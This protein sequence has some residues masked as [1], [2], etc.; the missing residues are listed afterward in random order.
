MARTR[1]IP[2]VARYP[3]DMTDGELRATFGQLP[4]SA[5]IRGL[6]L[7]EVAKI[8]ETGEARR[9][10]MRNLWYDYVKPI[11]S[12]AGRLNDTRL[13]NFDNLSRPGARGVNISI[14]QQTRTLHVTSW[15][16]WGE[17]QGVRLS[18]FDNLLCFGVCGVN[19]Y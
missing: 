15:R 14:S 13:S 11:L 16:S 9:R 10:T 5:V 4:N 12:R 8:R 7:A 19:D 6:I 3:F 18:N 17:R 1:I 2:Q